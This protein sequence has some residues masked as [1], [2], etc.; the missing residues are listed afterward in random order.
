MG[1]SGRNICTGGNRVSNTLV[2]EGNLGTGTQ[3]GFEGV[4]S[5]QVWTSRIVASPQI[6]QLIHFVRV[7]YLSVRD[8]M[9]LKEQSIRA[10]AGFRR[11]MSWAALMAG[12]AALMGSWMSLTYEPSLQIDVLIGFT[13]AWAAICQQVEGLILGKVINIRTAGI[14]YLALALTSPKGLILVVGMF[15]GISVYLALLA[16]VVSKTSVKLA[17]GDRFYK[18]VYPLATLFP[19]SVLSDQ[20]L[21][22]LFEPFIAFHWTVGPFNLKIWRLSI[23]DPPALH[24]HISAYALRLCSSERSWYETLV[25]F[26]R[27][28]GLLYLLDSLSRAEEYDLDGVALAAS[29]RLALAEI[30][31]ASKI[32]LQEVLKTMK[33]DRRKHI[34]QAFDLT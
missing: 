2:P 4:M 27:A 33:P 23:F 13:S 26:R 14:A 30:P 3:F 24:D 19:L 17:A 32:F 9:K 25:C 22:P 15:I 7:S 10:A 31:D 8:E 12:L 34:L 1:N 6:S 5:V 16:F 18:F 29:A 20:P 11:S 28:V 21:S